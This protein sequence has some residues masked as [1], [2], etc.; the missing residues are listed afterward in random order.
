MERKNFYKRID[1]LKIVA[2]RLG[3]EMTDYPENS[4]NVLHT[5]FDHEEMLNVCDGFELDIC[6]T[7]DH[8]PVVIHDK[9]IDDISNGKGYVK[10]YNLKE[11]KSFNFGYRN[12]LKKDSSRYLTIV[13]LEEMLEFFLDYKEL[14]GNKIIKIET[15]DILGLRSKNLS[16]LADLFN[17]YESIGNNIIHLSFF[18]N[19]LINLKKV[20]K[21]K[22]YKLTESDLLCDFKIVFS[23]SK[24]FKSLDRISLR[25]K[26]TSLPKV[27]KN[28]SKLVNRKIKNDLL[29]MKVANKINEKVLRKAIKRFGSVGLYVMNDIEE[30]DRFCKHISDDF[31]DK[32]HDKIVFTSDNPLKLKYINKSN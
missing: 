21:K 23:L 19:N 31:F 17:K 7:K 32:F 28:N 25:I 13:T 30:I 4:I 18:P 14:L 15:K 5:I 8:V 12:S 1:S 16:V 3:Y 27:S 2:H 22:G 9:Y 24:L 26:T 10:K 6:F 11:L 29:F 20:Q